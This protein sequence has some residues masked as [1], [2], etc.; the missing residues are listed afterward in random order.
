MTAH[1]QMSML[2]PLYRFCNQTHTLLS[3]WKT[4]ESDF[5]SAKIT[6]NFQ[7]CSLMSDFWKRAFCLVVCL[8]CTQRNQQLILCL[9]CDWWLITA[10]QQHPKQADF[11]I[12]QLNMKS[13]LKGHCFDSW[14]YTVAAGFR[15]TLMH[16]V[17]Y[18][19]YMLRFILPRIMWLVC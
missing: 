1:S 19:L 8:V 17:S 3:H 13:V 9:Y 7:P 10:P 11:V 18:I 15:H 16:T 6:S 12:L 14:I 5:M 4:I 2:N